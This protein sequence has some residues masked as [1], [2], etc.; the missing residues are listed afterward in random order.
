MRSFSASSEAEVPTSA[1]AGSGSLPAPAAAA[2]QQLPPTPAN[3][4][5][6]GEQAFPTS[7]PP[8]HQAAFAAASSQQLVATSSPP[9][10]TA[11]GSGLGSPTLQHAGAASPCSHVHQCIQNLQTI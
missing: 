1:P 10:L 9:Q 2:P 11:A 8:L 3:S 4:S 5:A 7:F 6:L